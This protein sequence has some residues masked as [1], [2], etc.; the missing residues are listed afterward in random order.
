MI[1][2]YSV[3]QRD[4]A[5]AVSTLE[6]A[7]TLDGKL[8]YHAVLSVGDGVEMAPVLKAMENLFARV[9]VIGSSAPESWPQGKNAAFQNLVRWLEAARKGESFFWWEPDA[10]PLVKGWLAEIEREHVA[11]GKP[12][13][14]CVHDA[15]KCME[16]VGVYPPNFM[17]YSPHNGMLCRA[18]P[19][20]RCC[21]LEILQS[22][23]RINH[24]MQFVNDVDGFPPTFTEDLSLLK[25]GAVLFHKNKD[26]SLVQQ[27]SKGKIARFIG[28]LFNMEPRRNTE[29]KETITVVFA[30]CARD[31][32]QAIH[33]ARWLKQ[34][35]R[36][37]GNMAKV[38]YDPECPAEKAAQL[39]GLLSDSFSMVVHCVYPTPANKSYPAVANYAFARAAEFMAAES[40]PWL[41][42][43]S[44]AVVLKADW[45][46]VLQKEYDSGGKPFMG[47]IVKEAGYGHTNG[48][49]IYP[50][51]VARR[52]PKAL[53]QT[54][55]AWDYAMRDE[56]NGDCHDASHL[57]QHL[58]GLVNG[59][60]SQTNGTQP[61]VGFTPELARRILL[62]SAVLVHRVKDNSLTD[63]L[64]KGIL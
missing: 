15:L 18:A 28:K 32:E 45:L 5:M 2:S 22:V 61:P 17:E 50:P 6:W 52:I 34:L 38:V 51:D 33:H 16:C 4:E 20:D 30:V 40:A 3:C 1:I 7:H 12:F 24:L 55:V 47:P 48:S 53:R 19:W 14:G 63:L 41:W 43:E 29:K 13:T 44:D 10:I 25:P 37:W 31:I 27:L 46:E 36:K 11:G 39:S 23:H 54:A 21:G 64:M 8:P 57:I 9:E 26:G 49:A 58:W 42:L 60:A 62:P 59:Q 35:G 56:V